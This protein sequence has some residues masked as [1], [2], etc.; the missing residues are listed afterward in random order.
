M[1]LK[2]DAREPKRRKTTEVRVISY[3]SLPRREGDGESDVGGIICSPPMSF[4]S[5]LTN[6]R[7]PSGKLI[8]LELGRDHLGAGGR[9]SWK[10]KDT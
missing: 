3:R 9:L 4:K 10:S 5:K 1:K 6:Q 7:G 2:G 8:K